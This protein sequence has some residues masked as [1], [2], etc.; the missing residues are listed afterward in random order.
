MSVGVV[1]QFGLGALVSMMD[2]RISITD[3]IF[4]IA[5]Y[6]H[7][8][9]GIDIDYYHEP[10]SGKINRMSNTISPFIDSAKSLK[11]ITERGLPHLV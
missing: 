8:A 10:P 4:A 5:H 7:A 1:M 2:M 11:R 3:S 9:I 6:E